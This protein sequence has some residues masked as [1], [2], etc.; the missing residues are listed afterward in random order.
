MRDNDGEV[1]LEKSVQDQIVLGEKSG[2]YHFNKFGYLPDVD[3]ADGALMITAD[4]AKPTGPEVL[5]TAETFSIAYNAA[6]DG[7]GTTGG[8]VLYF[9]YVDSAGKYAVGTHVL[10]SSSPDT[11]SFSGLGINRVAVAASG[12]SDVNV[13]AITITSSSSGGVHA[14]I[15]AGE[16]VTQ[17]ALFHTPGNAVAIAHLLFA[18]V[19]KISGG[20]SP[21]VTIKG[22]AHNRAVDTKFEVFRYIM[23]TAVE[24]HFVLN[25]PTGF[26]LSAGD[27]LYFTA[28]TNTNNTTVSSLR[29][30]L[31]LYETS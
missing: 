12:S 16:G 30:S 5:S 14:Y 18:N 10:G 11:T 29:F 22:W 25:E 28:A 31:N 21:R 19:N 26:K 24:N 13:N 1:S 27:I 3:T 20:G 6:T 9:V 23:D 2:V 8:T 4:P 15:P 7:S 17:Q